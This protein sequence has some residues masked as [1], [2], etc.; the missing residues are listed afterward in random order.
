MT[1]EFE[2]D[3]T[4]SLRILKEGGV[5]LYPT[6]TVWGLGCDATN[7]SAVKRIYEIKKRADEKAMIILV[8][9]ERDVLKHVASPDLS[10]FD[11]LAQ[12]PKPTTVIYPGALG[13]ADNLTGA[14]GSI[15]IRICNDIFCKHL[16]KRLGKPIVSTSANIS[17]QPTAGSFAGIS[18]EIKNQVDYIVHHR[19]EETKPAQP[20]S[21]IKWNGENDITVIRD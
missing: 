13:L 7:A 11:Y 14:D 3:I 2:E 20:S 19:Q 9:D 5:I 4:N 6:D 12:R 21:I 17:G 18:E 8:A 15:A 10:I 16:I 1:F